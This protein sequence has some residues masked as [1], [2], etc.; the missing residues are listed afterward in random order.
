M[1]PYLEYPRRQPKHSLGTAELQTWAPLN[2]ITGTAGLPEE[3]CIS[4]SAGAAG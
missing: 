3:V 2:E 1:T 4:H